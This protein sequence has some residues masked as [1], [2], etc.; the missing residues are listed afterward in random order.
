M[1]PWMC[2]CLMWKI[3][4]MLMKDYFKS[5]FLRPLIRIR[6]IVAYGLLAISRPFKRS[7]PF[8]QAARHDF[9]CCSSCAHPLLG[10]RL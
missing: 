2:Q 6:W 9:K 1:R 8:Y 10:L 3:C 5:E 7:T 4:P